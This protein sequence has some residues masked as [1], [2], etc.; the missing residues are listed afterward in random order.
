M[1]LFVESLQANGIEV[2]VVG[3]GGLLELPEIVDLVSAL[4]VIQRVDAGSELIRLL[5]GARW[6]IGAKDIDRLFVIAKKAFWTKA[7]GGIS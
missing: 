4:K 5:T 3:L 7:R 1:G 6:R 2:E